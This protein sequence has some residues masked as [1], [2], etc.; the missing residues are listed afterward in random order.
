MS[1]RFSYGDQMFVFKPLKIPGIKCRE[2]LVAIHCCDLA[3][4]K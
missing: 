4:T 3:D 1:R 2:K